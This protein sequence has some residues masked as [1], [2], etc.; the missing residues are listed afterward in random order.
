MK[1]LKEDV[2]ALLDDARKDEVKGLKRY[3]EVHSIDVNKATNDQLVSW[4]KSVK[5]FKKRAKKSVHQ[6]IR[7]MKNMRLR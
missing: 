2:I 4:I 3:V 1:V 7:N 5:I 6:D